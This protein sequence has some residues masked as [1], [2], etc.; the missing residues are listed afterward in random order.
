YTFHLKPGIRFGSPL[1]REIT[2]KDIEYAFRRIDTASLV[3]QYAFYY[4]GVI[5][6]MD[7]PKSKTPA[8]ISGIE[9]PDDRTIVFHLTKPTGDFLYRLAMPAAAPMPAEVADCFTRA[10]DYGRDVVS[11]GPY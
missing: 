7:G 9:T 10:G 11:T 8:D 4:D 3:A 6:G 2:S 5:E 1:Q